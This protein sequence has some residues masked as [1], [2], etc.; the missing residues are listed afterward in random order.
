MQFTIGRIMVVV[1]YAAVVSALVAWYFRLA[2]RERV[3]GV[4]ILLYVCV[5]APL[6]G[7]P[8]LAFLPRR[9]TRRLL[10]FAG[11]ACVAVIVNAVI[12]AGDRDPWQYPSVFLCMGTWSL[13]VT[14]GLGH[15]ASKFRES[16]DR[17]NDAAKP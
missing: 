13:G 4:A 6:W 17:P 5:L 14:C 7:T 11:C 8:I 10:K 2:P 9:L 1:G 3:T 16:F 12:H 15:L